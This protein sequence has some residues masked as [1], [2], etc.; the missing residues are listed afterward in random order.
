MS[1]VVETF[2]SG[3]K[4]GANGCEVG[5]VSNIPL[6]NVPNNFGEPSNFYHS[7]KK[8]FHL[9]LKYAM[10]KSG[11]SEVIWLGS[12][13]TIIFCQFELQMNVRK[14]SRIPLLHTIA[15]AS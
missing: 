1:L 4:K 10:T 7:F 8:G 3:G 6:S 15:I 14:T 12:S 11:Q 13:F 2:Y 5:L 9:H